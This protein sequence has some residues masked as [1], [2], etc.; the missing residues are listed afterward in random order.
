[1]IK[2]EIVAIFL[3]KFNNGKLKKN[4][5]T[6]T[7]GT[8]QSFVDEFLAIPYY[9]S[10]FKKKIIRIDNEIYDETIYKYLRLNLPDFTIQ[11]QKNAR[12]F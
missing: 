2:Y 8:I 4:K 12:Y 5:T 10:I 3:L 6:P 7:I 11:E 9:T 1:M